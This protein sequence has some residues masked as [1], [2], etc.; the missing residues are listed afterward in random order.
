MGKC[1]YKFPFINYFSNIAKHCGEKKTC[2]YFLYCA[3]NYQLIGNEDNNNINEVNYDK[4]INNIAL[5]K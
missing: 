4:Q 2:A 5:M 3:E 1:S